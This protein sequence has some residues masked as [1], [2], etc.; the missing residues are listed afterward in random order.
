MHRSPSA[1]RLASPV[2]PERLAVLGPGLVGSWLGAAC[3]ASHAIAGPSGRLRW[4]AASHDGVVRPWH[5]RRIRLEEV[6]ADMP[7]LAC[8]R[9]H[10][11]PW[12]RLPQTALAAQNG[13]GQPRAVITCFLALDP[14]PDG[15][16][17]AVGPRA[18][19]VLAP[20]PA[21][22]AGAIAA[23]RASGIAVEIVDDPRGAQWEKAILN[24][25]VGPLCL[26]TG[27]SM[28]AVWADRQLRALALDATREGARVA[29]GHGI[30]IASGLVD[31][32]SAFFAQVGAH[33][34]SVVR[35]PGELGAVIDRMLEHALTLGIAT[36]ALA[37]IAARAHAACEPRA[38]LFGGGT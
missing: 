2:P 1:V 11:T 3:G 36:P 33:L 9:V 28:A 26:A 29:R 38:A 22:F 6:P 14:G 27:L 35:E 37:R 13:L 18:R 32:A 4:N 31:R 24:A 30:A 16:V 21:A 5:P 34:P 19:L 17:A 12:E 20:P 10:A 25:T 15:V 8:S 23:W 7:L